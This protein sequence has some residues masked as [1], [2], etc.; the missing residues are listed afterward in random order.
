MATSSKPRPVF[1]Y[2]TLRVPNLLAWV[3]T[4]DFSNIT[5]VQAI[6]RPGKVY[7]Y[8]R[9]SIHDC[10]YPAAVK[11]HNSSSFVDGFLLDLETN[12]QRQ[13]LDDFE[14][15]QYK[16]ASVTVILDNGETVEADMYVWDDDEDALTALPWDLDWFIR[17]RSALWSEE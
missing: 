17:E 9:Y 14:G 12:S 1:I 16:A 8:A 11:R 10:D 15:D 6:S 7:G 3:L 13:K 4:H 2:G 5:V